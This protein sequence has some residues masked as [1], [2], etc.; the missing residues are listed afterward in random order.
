MEAEILRDSHPIFYG[1]SG[2]TIPVRYA[3]GP[4]LQ[5][6]PEDKKL[7]LMQFVGT[8]KS[9]LSGLMTRP[10]EIKDKAAIVDT[11]N[12]QGRVLMFA[13]NPW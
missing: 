1:Y 7:T 2:K 3:N 12:G 10:A 13:T 4:V 9:V 5:L 11:P 6:A 8:E